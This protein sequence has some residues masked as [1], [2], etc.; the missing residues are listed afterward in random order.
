M[1]PEHL[2]FGGGA[3]ESMFSPYVLAFVIVAGLLICFLPRNKAVAPFLFAAILIPIDQVLLVGSFHFPMLRVLLLF[4]MA[5][6]LKEI[7]SGRSEVL[8]GGFNSLDA[9]VALLAVF[10]AVSGAI[11]WGTTPAVV[12]QVG[13]L[14]SGLG[15]Y[16][17]LRC[18]IR[19]RDD[20]LLVIR[21][22][23]YLAILL[24]T[25]MSIELITGHNPLY[26]FLGGL[27]S[28]LY[29]S[30]I[31]RDG[32]L[33]ATGSFGHPILA[34]TFGAVLVPLFVGLWRSG[35][36]F[37]RTAIVGLVGATV[38]TITCN[39]S[40]PILAYVAGILGL[41]LWP[42]R[43]GMR[44]IR[45]GIVLTLV[46]LHMIMKAPVWNL[47]ARIGV[48]GASSG[49]HRYQLVN[50]CILHFSDWWFVGVKDTST[51]GWDMWDTA[52]QYVATAE[53]SGIVPFILFLTVIVVGFKYLKRARLAQGID[54]TSERF[55]WAV[56]ASLFANAVAFFGISYWDQTIVAWY[57]LL[58]IISATTISGLAT[59][60]ITVTH[61]LRA[62]RFELANQV[63]RSPESLTARS[64]YRGPAGL[65]LNRRS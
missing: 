62:P 19:D 8:S 5:R 20:V 30:V 53:N 36:Q 48:F 43:N 38:I 41:C 4:G 50:Q 17:L 46:F 12:Y 6:L 44:V 18:F 45:W 61:P 22:F 47:I 63:S 32:H 33:R 15:S 58:A 29:G 21:V 52:N 23:A 7:I 42:L 14:Y 35:T 31:Q 10:T 51:W 26:A 1:G 60:P 24:A 56:W 37:R 27:R 9:T 40:T 57:A 28:S 65:P 11:L 13:V 49:Y 54:E 16:F 64:A 39:S 25:L 3:A 34:G 59:N 55:I 2:K